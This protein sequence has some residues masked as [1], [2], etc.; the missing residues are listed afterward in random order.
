MRRHLGG[1]SAGAQGNS[2][3]TLLSLEL[4]LAL[5]GSLQGSWSA[6]DPASAGLDG[7]AMASTAHRTRESPRFGWHREP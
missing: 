5:G 6:G 2:N 7:A 4:Q 1:R 3:W